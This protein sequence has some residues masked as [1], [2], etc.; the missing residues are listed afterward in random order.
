MKEVYYTERLILRI[1]EPK[2]AKLVLDYLIRNK[3]FLREWETDR[4]DYYYTL[5]NQKKL[6]GKDY[7]R[8]I[9]GLMLRL[10]VFKKDEPKK[11]IG[12]IALDNIIRGPFLSS[13]IGYRLDKDYLNRG[14]T[15]EALQK[16][17]HIAFDDM[18]LHRLEANIMPRNSRSL[19]VVEKLGFENEGISRD[20][21]KINEKW[22]DHIHM[23]LLNKNI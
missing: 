9:E 2:D 11:V 21:L 5:S 7:E 14:Y 22:E 19:R 17:I 1:L 12:T 20:Y 13:F 10:W 23:V 15:T 6:L 4:S 8:Y 16:L 3:D 18:G